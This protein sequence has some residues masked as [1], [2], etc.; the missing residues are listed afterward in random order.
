MRLDKL[1]FVIMFFGS[2]L[3]T[4]IDNKQIK[5]YIENNCRIVCVDPEP[6]ITRKVR[7][8][9]FGLGRQKWKCIGFEIKNVYVEI[10]KSCLNANTNILF[11]YI[12]K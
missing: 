4:Y 9:N 1:L 11:I 2:A 8:Y 3:A 12:E 5:T 6:V 10:K 7:P